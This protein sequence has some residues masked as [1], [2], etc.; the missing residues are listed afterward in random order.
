MQTDQNIIIV[1]ETPPGTQDGIK[2][3]AKR[4]PNWM[5]G[6][7]FLAF[8]KLEQDVQAWKALVDKYESAGCNSADHCGAKLMGRWPS[9]KSSTPFI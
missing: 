7:T 1:S 2:A 3:E 5:V 6:G 8:R 9:G 4:R